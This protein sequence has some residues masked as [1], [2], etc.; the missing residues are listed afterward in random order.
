M[1]AVS[2]GE[3]LSVRT[4]YPSQLWPWSGFLAV[5]LTVLPAG[6]NFTG[7]VEGDLEVGGCASKLLLC[8]Y[9]SQ[10]LRLHGRFS[11]QLVRFV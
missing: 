10:S 5:V 11:H 3:L 6:A 2:G 7:I 4:Q 9:E 8:F 1:P